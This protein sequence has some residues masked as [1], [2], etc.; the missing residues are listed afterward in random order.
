MTAAFDFERAW[1]DKLHRAAS[2]HADQETADSILAGSE[3]H[4]KDASPEEIISWSQE[5]MRRLE[6]LVSD[7]S[8]RIQ[9]MT[10][11]ACQYPK[12]NLAPVAQAYRETGNVD[13]AIA[14]LQQMFEDFLRQILGADEPIVKEI[15]ELGWGSAG[16]RVGDTIQATKIPKSGHLLQYLQEKDPESRRSLYCHCPRVRDAL[17]LGQTVPRVYCY[18]GAGFYRGIWET[19]LGRQVD[20]SLLSSVLAGD[21]VCT[22][23]I[24]LN[25]EEVPT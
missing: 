16:S 15:R 13:V 18:C 8:T 11:C 5:A 6:S 14:M 23:A 2:T 4:S 9:I 7:E 12:A 22:V 1:L 25:T 21:D 24:R 19:I 10:D 20:V 3:D 17:E